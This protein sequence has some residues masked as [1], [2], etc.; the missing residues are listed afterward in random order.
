MS[1]Y[2]FTWATGTFLILVSMG[3]MGGVFYWGLKVLEGIFAILLVVGVTIV[4]SPILLLEYLVTG[5]TSINSFKFL[6]RK[7]KERLFD[8]W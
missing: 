7:K 8:D 5:K 6:N 2:E 3:M 4:A 1:H